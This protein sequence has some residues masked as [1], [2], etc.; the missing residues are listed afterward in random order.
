M[1][2]E[3]RIDLLKK[4]GQYMLSDDA[5]WVIAQQSACNMNA[6]FTR[7]SVDLSI[8]NI[9][10]QYLQPSLLKEWL[11]KY[12]LP[13]QAKKVGIIMAGNIPLVGFHDFLCCFV[14]AHYQ[15]IKL[16]SKDDVLLRKLI[17]K[18]LEWEPNLNNEIFIAD[19]LKNCEAYIAT[20]NNNSARYFEQYFG[21]YPNIIR[22]NRTSVAILEGTELEN[23]FTALANDV[24][25]YYGLGC[26]NVTQLCVPKGYDFSLLLESLKPFSSELMLHHKYKNNYDYYCAIYMLNKISFLTNDSLMLVENELPFSAV[27]VLHYRYYSNMQQL[28]HELEISGNVQTIVGRG[29]TPFGTAQIPSL[30]DYADGVDTMAFLCEI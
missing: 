7:E 30:S 17:E 12:S 1:N 25:S 3:K 18:L 4:L 29:F 5:D 19:N 2:I 16:S 9:V 8:Q 23:E 28:A 21:K 26:R 6:W 11:A 13:I 10:N 24:F 22:R 20:G 15:Y 14:C 27:S